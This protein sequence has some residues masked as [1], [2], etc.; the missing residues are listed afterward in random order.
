M[1]TRYYSVDLILLDAT[2]YYSVDSILLQEV[3]DFT[4]DTPSAW[5]IRYY[6][7]LLARRCYTI[8]LVDLPGQAAAKLDSQASNEAVWGIADGR[9]GLRL[10][11]ASRAASEVPGRTVGMNPNSRREQARTTDCTRLRQS[12]EQCPL[13]NEEG[14]TGITYAAPPANM[15][16]T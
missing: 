7:K 13:C 11:G 8:I 2:R 15:Q 9:G 10:D 6:S 3:P 12:D 1:A 5:S 16:T 4:V 14:V